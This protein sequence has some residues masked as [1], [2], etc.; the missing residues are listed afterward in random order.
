[1]EEKSA[2]ISDTMRE[3]HSATKFHEFLEGEPAFKTVIEINECGSWR[4]HDN[5]ARAVT[6]LLRGICF[7]ADGCQQVSSL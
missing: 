1:M 7:C 5:V 6:A 4:V 3:T 2:L